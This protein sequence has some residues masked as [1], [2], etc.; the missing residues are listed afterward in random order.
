MEEGLTKEHSKI[1]YGLAIIMMLYHHLFCI[2]SRLNCDYLA[3][4]DILTG[5]GTTAISVVL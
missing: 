4:P 1:L 5:G 2:P 3:V